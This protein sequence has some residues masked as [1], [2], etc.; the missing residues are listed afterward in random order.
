[1]FAF[2]D[3]RGPV[4]VGF[5]DRH[6]GVSEG[7]YSSLN[8]A[9][10]G[11]DD[12]ER[13]AENV[14]RVTAAFTGGTTDPAGAPSRL[15]RMRQV[16][17]ADVHV[18][19]DAYL[20]AHLDAHAQLQPLQH[21]HRRGRHPERPVRADPGR[22]RAPQRAADREAALRRDEVHRH[23]PRAHPRRRAALRAGR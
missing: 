9:E 12:S 1:V 18:V 13:V 15:V 21:E 3:S 23:R 2:Q 5:T 17:G 8:L 6:G 22:E 16:H 7:P 11:G 19:D 4:D 10:S 14:R 20:D